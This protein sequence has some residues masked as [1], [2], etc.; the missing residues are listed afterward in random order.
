MS[1]F[2]TKQTSL[3]AA[4]M[5]AFGGKANTIQ[6]YETG[7]HT[8]PTSRGDSMTRNSKVLGC[9]LIVALGLMLIVGDRPSR[10][11]QQSAIQRKPLLQQDA[12]INIVEIPV[13]VSEIRHTH[14]GPLAV[15]VLEGTLILEHEGRPT[16]TYKTGDAVLIEAGKVHR[17][18][19]TGTVPVKLVASLTS[20]KGKPASSPA[21]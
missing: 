7:V 8:K 11:Q 15:Y 3:V 10:A 19:N 1:A 6:H 16:T 13:G 12:T 4:Q 2:G 14:P 9:L 21:P 17:G 20:E 5:S 18:I